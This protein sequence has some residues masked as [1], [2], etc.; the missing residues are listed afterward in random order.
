MLI[1]NMGIPRSGTILI[2]N[3]IREILLLNQIV[4]TSNNANNANNVETE[5]FLD[6]YDFSSNVI[7]HTH[8]V[9]KSLGKVFSNK[10]THIFY[11]FRDPRDVLV[12]VMQLHDMNF[13]A[14]MEFVNRHF[15]ELFKI[16]KYRK[17]MLIPYE[18][19][20]NSVDAFVFQI[21]RNLGF[22]LNLQQVGR[23]AKDTDLSHAKKIMEQVASSETDVQIRHAANRDIKEDKATFINDRHIQSGA[24]GRWRKEL[25][26]KHQAVANRKFKQIIR[27]LGYEV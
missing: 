19:L 9:T 18:H 22:V 11:N 8:S 20:I 6:S 27:V 3:I 13:E 14:S 26:S 17:I 1:L 4:F 24:T 10:D 7:V 2:H 25:D 16:I 15:S 21:A 5:E 12:S 23:I